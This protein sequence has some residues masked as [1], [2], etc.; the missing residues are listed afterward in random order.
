MV[1]PEMTISGQKLKYWVLLLFS[2]LVTTLLTSIV[3]RTGVNVINK[4][5]FKMRQ[6]EFYPFQ[7][8]YKDLQTRKG[9][10]SNGCDTDHE[11]FQTNLTLVH[12]KLSDIVRT[13]IKMKPK[14]N[15]GLRFPKGSTTSPKD[16]SSNRTTYSG[17]LIVSAYPDQL[18]GALQWF[19]RF[20]TMSNELNKWSVEPFVSNSNLYGIPEQNPTIGS[21]ESLSMTKLLTLRDLFSFGEVQSIL[22]TCLRDVLDDFRISDMNE[23]ITS[24]SRNVVTIELKSAKQDSGEDTVF[25]CEKN[26]VV[27]HDNLKMKMQNLN[28]FVDL[29]ASNQLVSKPFKIVKRICVCSDQLQ[30]ERLFAFIPNDSSTILVHMERKVQVHAKSKCPTQLKCCQYR[31]W[32]VSK[33]VIEAADKFMQQIELRKPYIAIHVRIERLFLS[34]TRNVSKALQCVERMR[35]L[36]HTVKT[37]TNR[38]VNKVILVHDYGPNGSG[39]CY[40]SKTCQNVARRILRELETMDV[41]IVAYKPSDSG[42]IDERTFVS[43]VEKEVVTNADQL[44]LLGGGGFQ[45]SLYQMFMNK[46]HKKEDSF[47]VNLR[48][49]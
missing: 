5:T 31:T 18:S 23:F 41:H 44:I 9:C 28:Q 25:Y 49:C 26:N 30:V 42:G 40:R 14:E 37:Q 1:R 24:A 8:K 46:H 34:S 36:L 29:A 4:P 48:S 13:P 33:K 32:P 38:T 47:I 35:T 21:H 22:K 20:V 43:L 6:D 7:S 16:T 19:T 12:R 15:S 3:Y 27:M 39:S 17:Y 10:E 11:S 2:I 45:D